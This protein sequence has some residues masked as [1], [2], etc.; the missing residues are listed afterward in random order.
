MEKRFQVFVSS[1]YTDLKFER[2]AIIQALLKLNCFPTGMELFPAAN[3]DQ[4]TQIK[5]VI[6]E[7]DYYIV[8]IGGRYGSL[9]SDGVAY[10][11]KEYKYA[12]ELN[13]PILAFLH[14]DPDEIPYKHTEK[15]QYGQK[16]LK[17]FRKLVEHKP[18]SYWKS[19]NELSLKVMHSLLRLIET[20]PASGWVRADSLPDGNANCIMYPPYSIGNEVADILMNEQVSE[21]LVICYGTNRLGT[22]LH[23][24]HRK[25]HHIK[26][27]IVICSP[28]CKHLPIE[29]DKYDLE[30]VSEEFNKVHN[31]ELF[32][33]LI[34]PTI[35]GIVIR[36]KEKEPIWSS[37]QT[38]HMYH[39][40]GGL[41]GDSYSPAL[42]ARNK[43]STMMNKLVPS[44]A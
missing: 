32:R 33:S 28:D 11:E 41:F 21:V 42:I 8:I 3:E 26:F 43:E 35:R 20:E 4:W 23:E 40:P 34:L 14:L 10:T 17:K 30:K 12:L 15:S 38:Y 5:R 22:L 39:D 37:V 19:A 7:C 31:I 27:S 1:T 24:A 25:Y 16:M 44:P 13:K 18:C 6:S 2:Q 36:N 9:A 29:T